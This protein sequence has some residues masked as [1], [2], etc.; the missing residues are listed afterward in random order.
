MTALLAA[1]LFAAVL[2][3]QAPH[4]VHHLFD[5]D[6]VQPQQECV[7]AASAERSVATVAEPVI[8][9]PIHGVTTPVLVSSRPVPSYQPSRP[10][11]ARAPP[12][13]AS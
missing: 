8:F 4:T 12:P 3:W 11:P 7:F 9:L 10:A 13:A 1:A 5:R 2:V 6:H